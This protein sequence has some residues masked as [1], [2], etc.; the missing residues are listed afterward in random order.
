MTPGFMGLTPAFATGIAGLFEGKSFLDPGVIVILALSLLFTA[1]VFTWAAVFRKRRRPPG[2]RHH[3]S[4]ATT[5]SSSEQ[6][7]RSEWFP[8][9]RRR[10]Q[11][12]EWT[13]N[14]TLAETGG[15]PPMHG[16][17]PPETRT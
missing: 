10:R 12:R 1:A 7:K 16:G 9:R 8:R 4:P 6:K 13:R 3:H 11:R 15:L 17:E 5:Q 2:Y 14:P